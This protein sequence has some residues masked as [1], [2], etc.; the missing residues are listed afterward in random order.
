M[1]LSNQVRVDDEPDHFGYVGLGGFVVA[2]KDTWGRNI[3]SVKLMLSTSHYLSFG[4]SFDSSL[5]LGGGDSCAE[6]GYSALQVVLSKRLLMT[7]R[8][9]TGPLQVP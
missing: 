8:K 9:M 1:V 6:V 7:T 2:E 5:L 3:P 4:I